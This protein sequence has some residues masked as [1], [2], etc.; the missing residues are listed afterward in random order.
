MEINIK[1]D[2]RHWWVFLLRG[3]LFIMLGVY[4][5]STPGTSYLALS[6]LFGAVVLI[7]GI[8]ELLHVIANNQMRGK[9]L[10]I[11]SGIIDVVIGSILVSDISLSMSMLPLILSVWFLIRGLSLFSFAAVTRHPGW[12]IAGGVLTVIIAILMIFNPVLGAMTIVA[13][14]SAAFILVGIFNGLLA[15]RLKDANDFLKSSGLTTRS[16]KTH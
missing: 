2:I 13:W 10:R 15:F 11:V 5:L 3:L 7:A 9:S 6:L 1:E 14:T 4:M 16:T 8:I 12:L